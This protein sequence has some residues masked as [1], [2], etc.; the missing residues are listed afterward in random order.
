MRSPLRATYHGTPLLS[1]VQSVPPPHLEGIASH[2]PVEVWGRQ[3]Q[4]KADLHT[5]PGTDATAMMLTSCLGTTDL[6]FLGA[7]LLY[8]DKV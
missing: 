4:L 3:T 5:G 7:F 6:N 2:F 8:W 1:A